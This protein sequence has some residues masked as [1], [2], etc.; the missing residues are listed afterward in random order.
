MQEWVLVV[1]NC[2]F[3]RCIAPF[4]QKKKTHFDCKKI[5]YEILIYYVDASFVQEIWKDTEYRT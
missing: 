1:R 4:S 5:N 2:I 3:H